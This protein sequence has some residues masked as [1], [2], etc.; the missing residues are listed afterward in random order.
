MSAIS[1]VATVRPV[2]GTRSW[3]SA[4]LGTV[5]T[6]AEKTTNGRSASRKRCVTS[7]ATKAIAKPMTTAMIVSFTCS[8]S[9]GW[10]TPL[11]L[12]RTQS[13]QKKRFCTTQSLPSPKSGITG[14]WDCA[15]CQPLTGRAPRAGRG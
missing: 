1:T 13:A 10:M 3:N 14:S 4:R 6:I 9:A 7:A 8:R 15:S 11:Q 2:T 5:Y 12:S